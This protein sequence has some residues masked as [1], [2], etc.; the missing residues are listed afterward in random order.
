MNEPSLSIDIP[1][2]R[3]DTILDYDWRS[4]VYALQKSKTIP[5]RQINEAI[6]ELK[7][8]FILILENNEPLAVVSKIVDEAWHQF[9]LCTE[10]YG[11]FCSVYF[12]RYIHHRVNT[13]LTPVPSVAVRNTVSLYRKR[14]GEMPKIWFE[15]METYLEDFI[16]GRSDFLPNDGRWSGWPGY[17]TEKP[18]K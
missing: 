18:R 3:D 2:V 9:I 11:K 13:P 17:E 15:R 1:T 10:E 4:L 8:F 16:K 12:G 6:L 14:F 5:D 7:K